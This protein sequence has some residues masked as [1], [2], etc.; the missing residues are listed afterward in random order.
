MGEGLAHPDP[1]GDGMSPRSER[2]LEASRKRW[3]LRM[4]LAWNKTI[5]GIKGELETKETLPS[6][7]EATK[8]ISSHVGDWFQGEWA[9][10]MVV[11]AT[12]EGQQ[13]RS[14]GIPT[15]FD[16]TNQGAIASLKEHRL[17]LVQGFTSE[18]TRVAQT[19]VHRGLLEG[20]NPRAQAREF[21]ES[22]GL[23][24]K[25]EQHV[26]NYRRL[27]QT[28]DKAAL[29]RRLRDA[30]F[31]PTIERSIREGKPLGAEQIDKMVDRYRQRAVALRAETIA[32]T[33]SIRA[34]SA[35]QDEMYR[36]AVS[37]GSIGRDEVEMEWSTARD[38]RVR[39]SHFL[40][41]GQ[42]Q[43]IGDPFVSG[44]GNLLYYP[45][46]PDAPPEDTINCRCSRIP[47]HRLFARFHPPKLGPALPVRAT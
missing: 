33:E 47:R 26:S 45:S 14:L 11:T 32:R 38:E 17:R 10:L 24:E 4:R 23:T 20:R 9:Q 25:Q 44:L 41:N 27:L 30:R 12:R 42:R 34:L 3:E 22:I 31:D 13:L 7:P 8:I 6:D 2:E 29:S 35:G 18:Q 36:Q 46:D 16:G 1:P 43:K 37:E 5:A 39:M 19:A 21:R 40:M 28:Q 15:S